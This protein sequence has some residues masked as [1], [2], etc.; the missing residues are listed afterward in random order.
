M[1]VSRTRL[2]RTNYYKSYRILPHHI[3]T[4]VCLLSI[5]SSSYGS[6]PRLAHATCVR[7]DSIYDDDDHDDGFAIRR[8]IIQPWVKTLAGR[9]KLSGS[10]KLALSAFCIYVS[11]PTS[12]V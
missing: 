9:R 11:Y 3:I 1:L 2:L 4:A 8:A 10:F 7:T 6:K 5:L 12:I